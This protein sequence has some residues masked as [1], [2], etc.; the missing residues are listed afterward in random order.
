MAPSMRLAS[1]SMLSV[2]EDRNSTGDGR[3]RWDVEYALDFAHRQGIQ[4]DVADT[5]QELADA[6]ACAPQDWLNKRLGVL[7]TMFSV[8]RPVDKHALT[9]WMAESANLLCDLPHDILAHSIDEAIRKTPHGFV[10]SVGEIRRIADP[11]ADERR[12]H[13]DRLSQMEVALADPAASEERSRR[14]A[15]QAAHRAHVAALEQR[16]AE[17]IAQADGGQ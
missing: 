5:R 7:W 4:T 6:M 10:P 14:R 12:Q 16:R 13:I 8:G 9:V 11:L 17:R 3:P 1:P 15:E 2:L